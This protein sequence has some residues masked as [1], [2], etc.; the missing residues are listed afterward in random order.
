MH[1]AT[2]VYSFHF[3]KETRTKEKFFGSKTDSIVDM[4]FGELNILGSL[5]ASGLL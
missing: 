5:L 1:D 3:K 4:F 2:T